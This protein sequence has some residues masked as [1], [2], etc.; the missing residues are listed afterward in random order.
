MERNQEM[1]GTIP[2]YEVAKEAL[3]KWNGLSEEEA[4]KIIAESSYE[5]IERMVGAEGS[6]KYA[7]DGIISCLKN[8]SMKYLMIDQFEEIY[9]RQ[10]L[11]QIVFEG[12]TDYEGFGKF[13]DDVKGYVSEGHEYYDD[14][15]DEAK[16]NESEFALAILKNVHNGWVW[17]NR[18]QFFT[19]KQER[20][21]QYQYLPISLIGWDE[22]KSDLLFV[23]PILDKIGIQI[24]EN[25][26]KEVY[27]GKTQKLLDRYGVK[28]K[29]DLS[30]RIMNV[31]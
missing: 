2:Y 7:I 21:Q 1:N 9:L 24:D 29:E 13:L 16:F 14:F 28:S 30:D 19:K 5:E 12:N 25:E 3:M 18:E 8:V 6:M 26:L 23:K 10:A 20:G 15:F 31:R 27:C 11:N 22:A 4:N 17:D